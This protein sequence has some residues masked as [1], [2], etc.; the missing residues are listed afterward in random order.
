MAENSTVGDA[1]RI[2]AASARA[3]AQFA[4]RRY[5]YLIVRRDQAQDRLRTGSLALNGSSIV[6][7]L[8][9]LGSEGQA[10]TWVGFTQ[11]NTPVAACAFVLGTFLAGVSLLAAQNFFVAEASDSFVR[12][13]SARDWAA[14]Y[15]AP[16]T[17]DGWGRNREAMAKYH[18]SPL[19]DFQYSTVSLWAQT[20][21]GGC[22]LFGIITPLGHSLGLW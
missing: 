3:E 22:W 12:T 4:E 19:V 11:D 21:S 5:E 16:L 7:M 6:A 18:E 15:E 2:N 8:A 10:V 1:D 13:S 9:L 14:S 17:E 20:L